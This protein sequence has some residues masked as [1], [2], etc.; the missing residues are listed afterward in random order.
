M[1]KLFI[2]D[3]DG[4]LLSTE[5]EVTDSD[6]LAIQKAKKEGIDIAL[7]TGRMDDEIKQ[8]EK[9]LGVAV[10][11]IS[12]NGTSVITNENHQLLSRTLDP[13]I[14][15]QIIQESKNNRLIAI[16]SDFAKNYTDEKNEYFDIIQ[17]RL[18]APLEV[19]QK[20]LDDIGHTI[21]PSKI[22]FIGEFEELEVFEQ[23]VVSKFSDKI[24]TFISDRYCL[25]VVPNCV[26]KGV[27]VSAL[28]QNL[29]FKKEEIAC[30]GDSFNDIS[31]FELTPYSFAMENSFEDVK[32]RA[33]YIVKNVAEAIETVLKI[34]KLGEKAADIP[35]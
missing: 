34:N 12:Q 1:I 6:F 20:L 14:A 5:N 15:K 17:S 32:K 3:L 13:A 23:Q 22:F 27:A 29:G 11:R 24:Q 35:H 21:L 2:S 4:T 28:I 16:A 25:D 26:S 7:A 19:H 18:L 10:H 9:R 30:I 31:M 33:K 8:I